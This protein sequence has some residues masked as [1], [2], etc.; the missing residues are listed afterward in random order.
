MAPPYDQF[1]T[2]PCLNP[3][4]LHF[5]FGTGQF[6]VMQGGK[7][8]DVFSAPGGKFSLGKSKVGSGYCVGA[9]VETRMGV[10]ETKA[11]GRK[12]QGELGSENAG[13]GL[14][15]IWV[16]GEPFWRGVGTAFDF[17]ENRVGVRAF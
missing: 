7:G 2:F 6:P 4:V 11:M 14:K 3:P 5:E 16:I 17:S 8:A 13:N 1:Y 9:V 10:D 12:R 15:D